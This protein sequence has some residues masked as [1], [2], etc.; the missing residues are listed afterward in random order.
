MTIW[1]LNNL[2]RA[3]HERQMLAELSEHTDWLKNLCVSLDDGNLKANFDIKHGPDTF[4]LVLKYP[5]VFPDAP[6]L[7]KTRNDERISG[8]QYG[9][10]G[11]LCLEY[12]PDNWQQEV[13]GAMMIESAYRLLSGERPSD[14]SE[15]AEIIDGHSVSIGQETRTAFGRFVMTSEDFAALQSLEENVVIPGGIGRLFQDEK[16][17]ARIMH[18]GEADSPSWKSKS[19]FSNQIKESDVYI[20]KHPKKQLVNE[21]DH[22]DASSCIASAIND[23][24]NWELLKDG[25]A[26]FLLASYQDNWT[27]HW[28]YSKS[29]DPFVY[30]Y[31]TLNESNLGGRLPAE[32][33]KLRQVKIG[34]VGCGSMGSKIAIQLVRSGVASFVLID[35]DVFFEHN[36]VRHEL[37]ATDIGFHK[38]RALRNRLLSVDRKLSIKTREIKLGGQ[39][40]SETIITAMAQLADCDLIVDATAN[41]SAFN[42]IAAVCKRGKIPVVWGSVFAGGIGGIIGRAIPDHD[43]EPINARQQVRHWCESQGIDAPESSNDNTPYQADGDD[44]EPVIATDA[45]VSV[46]AAH[47]SRFVID[48][49]CRSERSMFPNSAYVIGLSDSWI[50]SAPFDTRPIDF[51]DQVEWSSGEEKSTPEELS[52]FLESVISLELEDGS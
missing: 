51:T 39:E 45:D 25:E 20:I 32:L 28:V 26:F 34:I 6:P 40:S 37:S 29:E 12:R 31:P 21:P 1:W 16:I 2:P 8:H 5:V 23:N 10:S 47:V 18:I 19:K 38:S 44:G 22:E 4:E 50:F 46:I 33:E 17:S 52:E 7:V 35:D 9:A 30:S 13:T 36:L 11:E 15:T 42:T 43:P 48:S 41:Y 49:L 24:F 14:S 3:K 27:L